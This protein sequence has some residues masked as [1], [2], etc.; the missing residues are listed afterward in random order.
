MAFMPPTSN[1]FGLDFVVSYIKLCSI[2]L[3]MLRKGSDR[4]GGGELDSHPLDVH[5]LDICIIF[6]S[7]RGVLNGL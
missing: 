2:Y 4:L 1:G 3:D 7:G 6:L 5:Q